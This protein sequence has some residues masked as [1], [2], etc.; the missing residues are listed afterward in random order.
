MKRSASSPHA[1]KSATHPQLVAVKKQKNAKPSAPQKMAALLSLLALAACGG[2][3]SGTAESPSEAQNAN[4]SAGAENSVT[5]LEFKVLGENVESVLTHNEGSKT[6]SGI[7]IQT[8]TDWAQFLNENGLSSTESVDFRLYDVLV[9]QKITSSSCGKLAFQELRHAREQ[10]LT[11]GQKAK[12]I[13]TAKVDERG[14]SANAEESCLTG[15][16]AKNI[17]VKVNKLNIPVEYRE[18][19]L[20]Y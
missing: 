5:P 9:Y 1:F 16:H 3:G 7:N 18:I 11:D 17:L 20:T 15:M 13:L 10:E 14:M 2:T 6:E 8:E 4:P 19:G 12:I